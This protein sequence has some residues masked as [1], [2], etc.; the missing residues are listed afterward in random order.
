VQRSCFDHRDGDA[1]TEIS[2]LFGDAVFGPEQLQ[3]MGEAFDIAKKAMPN[4][5][6][7]QIAA[8]IMRHA[9]DG[10]LDANVLCARTLNDLN[11]SKSR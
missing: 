6:P 11:A 4:I 10:T 1:V 5:D 3:A 9:R 7:Y 8:T 2:K